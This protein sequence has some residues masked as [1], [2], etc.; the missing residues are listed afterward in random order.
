MKVKFRRNV[1]NC[2]DLVVS[3]PPSG[4]VTWVDTRLRMLAAITPYEDDE[5]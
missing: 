4:M 3:T 2:I 1:V 5:L